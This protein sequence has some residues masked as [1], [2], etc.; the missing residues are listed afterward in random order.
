MGVAVAAVLLSVGPP[1][2]H[3]FQA[4]VVDYFTRSWQV[5]GT[6]SL[7]G[8]TATFLAIWVPLLVGILAGVALV[9]VGS[10]GQWLWVLTDPRARTAVSLDGSATV[11]IR[12]GVRNGAPVWVL[13]KH[14]VR[15]RGLGQ[16]ARLRETLRGPLAEAA[17]NVPIAAMA[18]V[19]NRRVLA[20]LIRQFP[21]ARVDGRAL[22][23][24]PGSD[25][26]GNGLG[27]EAVPER[28]VAD[29]RAR[30]AAVEAG[31]VVALVGP[32]GSGKT[33]ILERVTP[34][35]EFPPRGE[36]SVPVVTFNPWMFADEESLFIG[37]TELVLNQI[38]GRRSRKR[39]ARALRLIGPSS[40]YGSFD[41][42][43][44]IK[45]LGDA[46]DPRSTPAS[47][48][49]SFAEGVR[50]SR[51]R[52]CIVMDDVDRLNPDELITLFK[53][54]RLVGSL[55]GV[56][57]LLSYDEQTVLHLLTKTDIASD[58]ARR[59]GSYLEKI[60]EA[61]HRVPPMTLEQ[62]VETG[63]NAVTRR[64][65]S[66]RLNVHPRSQDSLEWVFNQSL[67]RR[68]NTM[69]TIERFHGEVLQL[70]QHLQGD[71]DYKD[72]VLAAFLKSQFPAV[73]RYVTDHRVEFL[74]KHA[75]AH[76]LSL[77]RD[78]SKKDDPFAINLPSQLSGIGVDG[79]GLVIVLDVL[80]AMFP[81]VEI[82]S[83][84]PYVARTT[85]DEA[86]ARKGIGHEAYF[87]RYTWEGM[88]PNDFSDQRV[89]SLAR[90]LPDNP[91]H[92]FVASELGGIFTERPETVLNILMRSAEDKTL[93]KPGLVYFLAA[94]LPVGEEIMH[95]PSLSA[96]RT[97]ILQAGH[98]LAALPPAQQDEVMAWANSP[99]DL[100]H[101][102]F[103]ELVQRP[104]L[105]APGT[106]LANWVLDHTDVVIARLREQLPLGPAPTHDEPTVRA[107][108][109][110]L[111]NLDEQALAADLRL[112][113]TNGSWR[114]DDTV[115]LFISRYSGADMKTATQA[116]VNETE[117]R[118]MLGDET[119]LALYPV[120]DVHSVTENFLNSERDRTYRPTDL[121]SMR[122][123][124][125][126]AIAQ[127]HVKL[128]EQPSTS[129][130]PA[131]PLR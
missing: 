124:A 107:R 113:L 33:W 38:G 127:L 83:G 30:A 3:L 58:D 100:A 80:S 87:D 71:V 13:S 8:V 46:L 85:V 77:S 7:A 119:I 35:L 45:Q 104:N 39:V 57:Y 54:I 36:R 2:E 18:Q 47:V 56:T 12:A 53:L 76:D 89:V 125:A 123:T 88:P 23:W 75:D 121:N 90:A 64:F 120:N 118:R 29:V 129:Q 19:R 16:G 78:K 82:R 31:G 101:T 51:R 42:T 40:K 114:A 70:P 25:D 11:T 65:E 96:R 14:F 93:A 9:V 69:R 67:A 22:I 55:P 62:I 34:L 28:I 98:V 1:W 79:D 117:I 61:K 32:W 105:F 44:V 102:L 86:A 21:A 110:T 66:D 4:T 103:E 115:A 27:R 52:V 111:W 48:A 60:V 97:A 72:W 108:V 26:R 15:K 130:S 68:L 73:W 84:S 95:D 106:A 109:L 99:D 122:E 37:F 92:D 74:G 63:L 59:A 116:G 128:T 49:Q 10:V 50:A 5:L 24:T 91:A 112:L 81:A 131:T 20:M 6:I 126:G 17:S 94:C 41:L 43:G